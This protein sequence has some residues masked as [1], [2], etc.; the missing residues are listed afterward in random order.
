MEKRRDIENAG[1]GGRFEKSKI[2]ASQIG[3]CST[4]SKLFS[5]KHVAEQQM[6]TYAMIT[7]LKA[8]FGLFEY[9]NKQHC[10]NT[11]HFSQ[12]SCLNPLFTTKLHKTKE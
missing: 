6:M 8:Y 3:A 12:P 4:Y 10:K 1:S 11:T 2:I 9:L 7:A 5:M